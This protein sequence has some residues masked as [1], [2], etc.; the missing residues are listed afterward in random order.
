M[1]QNNPSILYAGVDV[2]KASFQLDWQ[3]RSLELPN[4]RRGHTRLLRLLGDPTGKQV[5][6]EA[7][8]GYEQP[9]LKALRKGGFALSVLDP[10]RVRSFA[11]V[12]GLRAKTDPLDAALIRQFAQAIAPAPT[13]APSPDQARLVALVGRRKQLVE[14]HTAEL[15]HA[16]HLHDPLICRQSKALRATLQ[17]QI[18][19]CERAIAELIASNESMQARSKRIQQV[20]GVGPQVAATLQAYLPELG[21][22][23]DQ[24]ITALVGLA[25]FNSDSGPRSGKR[26]IAG[27]R[28]QPRC[29]LYM[30]ALSAVRHDPILKA[31]YQRLRSAGKPAK[32][33]LTAAMR[34]LLILLNRLLKHP[35]FSLALS[36]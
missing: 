27:G 32:L 12:K 15:N 17:K 6:L 16:E 21:S 19:Q 36:S 5:A 8:G 2:A 22:Y 28:S 1:S 35:N 11:R 26:R 24:S 33:A 20:P 31:F 14:L 7:S 13:P 34:K 4:D 29:A 18:A 30:A 10:A 3:E 9:I 25:P 23:R